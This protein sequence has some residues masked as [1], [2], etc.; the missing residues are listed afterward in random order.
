MPTGP[1][2]GGFNVLGGAY[3]L[4][5]LALIFIPMFLGRGSSPNDDDDGRDD[6]PGGPPREPPPTPPGP[7]DRV[8]MPDA[9]PARVRLR[10]PGRIADSLPRRARRSPPHPAP[11]RH[12]PRV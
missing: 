11:G 7:S 4:V 10:G 2:V 1:N 3:L 8:P 6:G 5:V 12:R 9:E